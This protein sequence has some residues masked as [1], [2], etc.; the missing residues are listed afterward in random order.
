M[1]INM[2][3]LCP[4]SYYCEDGSHGYAAINSKLLVIHDVGGVVS[5]VLSIVGTTLI[6][7]AY[8]AFKDLRKRKAQTIITLL[9]LADM[10]T[11]IACLLGLANHYIFHGTNSDDNSACWIFDNICQIQASFGMWCAMSSSIWS[12]VLAVHFLLASLFSESRWT[13]RLLPLYNI[14]AWTLPIIV[15][16][17]LLITG[18]LGYTPTYLTYCYISASINAEESTG[19]VAMKNSVVWMIVLSSSFI[20][21][22]CYT[23]LFAL[24][25]KKVCIENSALAIIIQFKKAL[26]KSNF[27]YS[28]A[29]SHS[30][31]TEDCKEAAGYACRIPAVK[32]A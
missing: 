4:D 10:G 14:V 13:E 1:L 22:M 17:P 20:T 24:V 18:Q 2:E 28:I 31:C 19:V 11:A 30:S 16:L 26:F 23:V 12:T 29:T 21:V 15:I 6:L 8:C 9:S 25:Y 3:G 27:F 7:L 5:S 32:T